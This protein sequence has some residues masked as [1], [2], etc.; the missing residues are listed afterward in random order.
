MADGAKRLICPGMTEPTNEPTPETPPPAPA[1]APAPEPPPATRIVVTG[2]KTEREIDLE[3]RLESESSARKKAETDA[4][5][6]Q[7]AAAKLREQMTAVHPRVKLKKVSF[8]F[9]TEED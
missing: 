1:A 3:N 5:F 6:A 9:F 7:D 4:A 8:G 2:T